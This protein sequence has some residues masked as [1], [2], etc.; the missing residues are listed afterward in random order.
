MTLDGAK[1][2]NISVA[3]ISITSTADKDANIGAALSWVQRAAA[4]G[5]SWVILPEMLNYIGP[6]HHLGSMAEAPGSELHGIFSRSAR[7]HGITLFAGSIAESAP[8]I[9]RTSGANKCSNVAYVYRPDGALAARYRKVHLFNLLN[10]HG[11][12]VY[13]E[14]EGYEAGD[15]VCVF[16]VDGWR[17]G[18]AICYDLRFPGFF[19]KMIRSKPIDVLV[20]PSAFTRETGAAHWHLLLRAR[21]VDMQCYVIAANQVGDHQNG[22]ASFGHSLVID[23]WGEVVADSGDQP[24]MA[25]AHMDKSRLNSVRS[26]LPALANRRWDLY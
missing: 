14:S 10:E 9:N 24:G 23:P 4:S 26:R 11:Q 7:Q 19:E 21:A 22:K 12:H 16:E 5:A 17:V 1:T 15:D 6:Y 25:C 3:A 8:K 20:L 18:L 2:V 13:C